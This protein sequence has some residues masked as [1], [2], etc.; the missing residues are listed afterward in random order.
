MLRV[1]KVLRI[2]LTCMFNLVRAAAA[3]VPFPV[4]EMVTWMMS[5]VKET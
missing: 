3:L 1:V 4:A 2:V 5:G